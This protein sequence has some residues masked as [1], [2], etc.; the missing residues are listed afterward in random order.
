MVREC[1]KN[2]KGA[3]G[4][5]EEEKVDEKRT[6]IGMERMKEKEQRKKVVWSRR[7][8]GSRR[9]RRK[10]RTKEWNT[11]HEGTAGALSPRATRSGEFWGAPTRLRVARLA[12]STRVLLYQ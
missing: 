8:K 7:R 1:R 2:L 6:R 9:S 12:S 5:E 4:G 11:W 3:G 10:R